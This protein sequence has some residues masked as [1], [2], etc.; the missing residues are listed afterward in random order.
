MFP[1]IVPYVAM[2]DCVFPMKTSIWSGD[3][4][5]SDPGRDCTVARGVNTNQG[6]W[7]RR[8]EKKSAAGY[9]SRFG[10]ITIIITI[11]TIIIQNKQLPSGYLT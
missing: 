7:M 10:T 3:S 8:R 6:P 4:P 1:S 11:I 5:G 2:F 9:G